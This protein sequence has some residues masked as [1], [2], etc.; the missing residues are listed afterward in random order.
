MCKIRESVERT[1]GLV[2]NGVPRLAPIYIVMMMGGFNAC[3]KLLWHRWWMRHTIIICLLL[4][5]IFFRKKIF[6]SATR[7]QTDF[8]QNLFIPSP[9][10]ST[11]ATSRVGVVLY[12]MGDVFLYLFSPLRHA[13]STHYLP[14]DRKA[15]LEY[16]FSRHKMRNRTG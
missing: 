2:V 7:A 3:I 15:I 14:V 16:T 10:T 5:R 12:D 9:F 4:S 13:W 1:S 6:R 11:A 8:H